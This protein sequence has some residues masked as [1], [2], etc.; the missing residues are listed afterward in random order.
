MVP[1]CPTYETLISVF[2]LWFLF[3]FFIKTYEKNTSRSCGEVDNSYTLRL[4]NKLV[5]PPLDGSLAVVTKT[6]SPDTLWCGNS[7][8]RNLPSRCILTLVW[9][10]CAAKDQ[11]C[12]NHAS[13]RDFNKGRRAPRWTCVHSTLPQCGSGSEMLCHCWKNEGDCYV[14]TWK[15]LKIRWCMTKARQETLCLKASIV[16]NVAHTC[17][18][19]SFWDNPPVITSPWHPC[20]MRVCGFNLVTCF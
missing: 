14:L 3:S 20:H 18:L 4:E 13:V 9:R 10:V 19:G 17:V 12:P 7:T 16:R 11:K 8:C 15:L 1:I 5:Q 2:L 6:W